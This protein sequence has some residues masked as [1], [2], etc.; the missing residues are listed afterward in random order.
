MAENYVLMFE[1][2]EVLDCWS[3]E[4]SHLPYSTID[5]LQCAFIFGNIFPFHIQ[6]ILCLVLNFTLAENN[7]L[8]YIFSTAGIGDIY[9]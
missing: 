3:G 8:L 7:I 9:P 4:R 2:F 6:N 5:K 1:Y